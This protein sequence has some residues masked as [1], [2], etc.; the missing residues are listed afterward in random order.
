M[1]LGEQPVRF[2]FIGKPAVAVAEHLLVS[3]Y[4]CCGC[5]GDILNRRCR[6]GGIRQRLAGVVLGLQRGGQCALLVIDVAKIGLFL[7]QTGVIEFIVEST[8][9]DS[10]KLIIIGGIAGIPELDACLFLVA[11]KCIGTDLGIKLTPL[12]DAFGV[13]C[14]GECLFT[15]LGAYQLCTLVALLLQSLCAADD[16][17]F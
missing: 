2:G 4:A 10:Q 11:G 3:R 1:C 5:S 13:P 15:L 8:V 16:G 9:P 14:V 12:L 6:G 17:Y 7:I